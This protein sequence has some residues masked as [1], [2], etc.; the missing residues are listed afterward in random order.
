MRWSNGGF[1]D[2]EEENLGSHLSTGVLT[3]ADTITLGGVGR[4][5]RHYPVGLCSSGC[6]AL[7]VDRIVKNERGRG[8][9][10]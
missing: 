5:S 7:C 9:S 4:C 1:R 8:V 10:L 2:G 3:C 6:C